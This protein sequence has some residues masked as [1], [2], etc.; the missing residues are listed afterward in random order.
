MRNSAIR[1]EAL[2]IGGRFTGIVVELDLVWPGM[3]RVRRGDDLSD[4]ANISRAKDAAT[5]G[6][7]PRG[8]GGGEV[9][10]WHHRESR[11][12]APHAR[13]PDRRGQL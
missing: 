13:F 10:R 4:M 3:W 2:F 8:L 9:A 6:A 11:V 7:R 12:G 1:A 5:A